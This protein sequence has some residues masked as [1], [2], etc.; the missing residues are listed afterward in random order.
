M[1]DSTPHHLLM[2]D[3]APGHSDPDPQ[4]T[5]EWRDAF[6]ALAAQGQ[7]RARQILDE[8]ARLAREQRVGWKPELST[9][10]L[11]TIG[12]NEQPV[13]PGDLAMEERLASPDLYRDAGMTDVSVREAI[14]ANWAAPASWAATSPA[15]PAPP[16]CLK[17]ASIISF[18]RARAWARAST[19]ATWCSSSRTARLASMPAPTW[20]AGSAK[21]T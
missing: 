16:T 19:A 12:V 2:Q 7:A 3:A 17:P 5:A 10:Y 11:N 14:R 6:E 4:E 18:T 9:P 1:N 13:F 15:M 20:K 21:R 8:L